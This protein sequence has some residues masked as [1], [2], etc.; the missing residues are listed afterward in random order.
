MTSVDMTTTAE[1]A[2]STEVESLTTS[3]T[4]VPESH[5]QNLFISTSATEVSKKIN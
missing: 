1:V 5:H 3:S 4:T 2:A